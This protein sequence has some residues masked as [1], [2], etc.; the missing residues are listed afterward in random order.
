MQGCERWLTSEEEAIIKDEK[1][2]MMLCEREEGK[3]EEEEWKWQRDEGEE[4]G[5]LEKS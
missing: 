3:R 4:E 2:I 1:A 5:A